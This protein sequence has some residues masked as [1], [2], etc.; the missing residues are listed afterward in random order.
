MNSR[1]AGGFL[2]CALAVSC[3]AQEKQ[4]KRAFVLPQVD[5]AADPVTGRTRNVP[6]EEVLRDQLQL[7]LNDNAPIPDALA[8][9][10]ARMGVSARNVAPNDDVDLNTTSRQI[11]TYTATGLSTIKIDHIPLVTPTAAEQA[12]YAS[13]QTAFNAAA[14]VWANVWDSPVEV[15]I[16]STFTAS[17][18]PNN[19]GS[20]GA[21]RNYL[22]DDCRDGTDGPGLFPSMYTASLLN[23]KLG[24]DYESPAYHISMN[25][26]SAYCC[27]N[28]NYPALPQ[29]NE[30]D[31]MS[32][33]LHEIGH[34]LYFSSNANGVDIPGEKALFREALGYASYDSSLRIGDR[35]DDFMTDI[36]RNSLKNSC[37]DTSRFYDL[38]TG[39]GTGGSTLRFFDGSATA[40]TDFRLYTPPA[41]SS[42][43][44]VS[45]FHE[46]ATGSNRFATLEQDCVLAGIPM[47]QCSTLMSPTM[48][49]GET[50]RFVGENDKR[51]LE[52][53]ASNRVGFNG[54]K[55][56]FNIFDASSIP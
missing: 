52:S 12:N 6:R 27:W 16:R 26:N 48:A 5:Y 37:S 36:S 51:V 31:L 39:D 30:Q 34:G 14:D 54:E 28:F 7:L 15:R 10:A 19:L 38:V 45:H 1:I 35:F 9:V 17:N 29:S 24:V 21:Y 40:T 13:A 4:F 3:A 41:F 32:T 44:S 20:A 22:A 53:M 25:M 33:A 23:K 8:A 42:G 46:D 18:N 55:C 43:S 49:S 50:T 11:V 2:L 47:A 56:I